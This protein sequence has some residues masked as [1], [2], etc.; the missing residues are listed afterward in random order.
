[1]TLILCSDGVKAKEFGKLQGNCSLYMDGKGF[2]DRG[3]EEADIGL[4]S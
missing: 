4:V 3:K 1:M 2:N